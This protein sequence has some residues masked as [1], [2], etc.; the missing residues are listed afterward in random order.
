MLGWGAAAS[1]LL[2]FAWTLFEGAAWREGAWAACAN[3]PLARDRGPAQR[4]LLHY[5]LLTSVAV[6]LLPILLAQHGTDSPRAWIAAFLVLLVGQGLAIAATID[7]GA[8]EIPDA[9]TLPLLAVALLAGGSGGLDP[10]VMP[11][12]AALGAGLGFTLGA[13]VS[14]TLG[15]GLDAVGGADMLLLSAIGAVTGPLGLALVAVVA[16]LATA[17]LRHALQRDD[18]TLPYAPGLA[19]GFGPAA[20]LTAWFGA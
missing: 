20:A 13:L 17:L 2:L 1:L 4:R 8:A 3:A 15:R 18:G 10:L 6:P 12:Q 7:E 9:V 11:R 19:L 16:G 5:A 14:I